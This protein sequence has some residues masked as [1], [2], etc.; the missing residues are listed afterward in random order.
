MGYVIFKLMPHARGDPSFRNQPT[1][2]SIFYV[3]DNTYLLPVILSPKKEATPQDR[4]FQTFYAML[5]EVVKS[6]LD[7]HCEEWNDEAI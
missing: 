5:D 1:I 4:L 7:C 6:P 3:F 2:G